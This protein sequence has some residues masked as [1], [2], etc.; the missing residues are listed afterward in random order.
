MKHIPLNSTEWKG[1]KKE[2]GALQ[3]QINY[4]IKGVYIRFQKTT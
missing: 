4:S 3:I 1:E 2:L